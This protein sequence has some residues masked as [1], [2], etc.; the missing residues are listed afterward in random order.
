MDRVFDR[1]CGM[2]RW[3]SLRVLCH[4]CEHFNEAFRDHFFLRSRPL[5]SRLN[6][7]CGLLRWSALRVSGYYCERFTVEK[8][9]LGSLSIGLTAM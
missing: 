4:Y 9:C 6:R 2:E 3:S 7:V 1:V 8:S 5:G